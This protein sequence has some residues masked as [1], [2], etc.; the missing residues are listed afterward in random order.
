MK[1]IIYASFALVLIFGLSITAFAEDGGEYGSNGVTSFFG[2]YEY[3]TEE[4]ELPK[5]EEIGTQQVNQQ[6][7]TTLP[8]TGSD[9]LGY[10]QMMGAAL[11]VIGL[12]VIKRRE[13][14]EEKNIIDCRHSFI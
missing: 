7:K 8:A 1:K 4:K 2:V 3:P 11:L 12:V 5:E 14:N 10:L 9:H 13:K 6:G